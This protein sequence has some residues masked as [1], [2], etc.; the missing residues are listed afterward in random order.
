LVDT[1]FALN[2]SKPTHQA[3]LPS[4]E[5]LACWH[6]TSGFSAIAAGIALA[7]ICNP[8][9]AFARGSQVTHD[10]PWIPEHI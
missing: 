8:S 4:W 7:L 6:F 2:A 5:V 1:G 9:P 10:D 3:S